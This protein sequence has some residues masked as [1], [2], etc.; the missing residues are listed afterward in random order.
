MSSRYGCCAISHSDDLNRQ[1]V[2]I[3]DDGSSKQTQLESI[4]VVSKMDCPKN[5]LDDCRDTMIEGSLS[6]IVY[7]ASLA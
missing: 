2:S 3:N 1:G 7:G 5:R 6:F 4:R